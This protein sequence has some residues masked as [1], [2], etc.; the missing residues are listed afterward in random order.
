[1]LVGLTTIYALVMPLLKIMSFDTFST[2]WSRSKYPRVHCKLVLNHSQVNMRL[3]HSLGSLATSL[4]SSH[5]YSVCS[6]SASLSGCQL[7]KRLQKLQFH[8]SV[9]SQAIILWNF[10]YGGWPLGSRHCCWCHSNKTLFTITFVPMD[11]MLLF[12][13][14]LHYI[15]V[16]L[17][18]LRR[19]QPT[20]FMRVMQCSHPW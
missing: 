4:W 20:V 9:W 5:I 7:V 1:M 18:S 10:D 2:S 3:H 8:N 15:T 14:Y 16:C 6:S 13:W 11:K 17:P 19:S 12:Y